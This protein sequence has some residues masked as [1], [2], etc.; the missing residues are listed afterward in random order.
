[1]YQPPGGIYSPWRA[2]REEKKAM[3]HAL[4]NLDVGLGKEVYLAFAVFPH[5]RYV[6]PRREVLSRESSL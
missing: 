3:S 2:Q 6:E 5:M 4:P 1:M